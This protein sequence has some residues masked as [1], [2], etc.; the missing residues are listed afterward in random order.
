[1]SPIWTNS[2]LVRIILR[3]SLIYS[4]KESVMEKA[5]KL[6]KKSYHECFE[7]VSRSLKYDSNFFWS[8]NIYIYTYIC[9]D[10]N[11]DHFTPLAQ[12]N[13]TGNKGVAGN[14]QLVPARK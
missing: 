10:T 9:M 7:K 13:E 2:A 5:V 6:G 11:T 12:G 8:T 4:Y 14:F 1:M 3:K